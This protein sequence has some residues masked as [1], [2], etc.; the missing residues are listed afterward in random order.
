ML[1]LKRIKSSFSE[2]KPDTGNAFL[3]LNTTFKNID[4]ESRTIVDGSVFIISN[5]KEYEFDKS[6]T[7]MADGYGVFLDQINPLTSKTT[8]LVYQ[9]PVDIKGKLYY[10]P[11]R[12]DKDQRVYL[13]NL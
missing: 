1:F 6:E 3:I 7:I 12:S 4:T 8:K 13:G 9:I 10:N 2:Y 5:G 11:G